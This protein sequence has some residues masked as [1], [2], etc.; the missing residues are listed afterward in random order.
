MAADERF[1]A[2][3]QRAGSPDKINFSLQLSLSPSLFVFLAPVFFFISFQ[4]KGAAGRS[5]AETI[6]RDLLGGQSTKR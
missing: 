6:S 5:C 2:G 4:R 1:F 3:K